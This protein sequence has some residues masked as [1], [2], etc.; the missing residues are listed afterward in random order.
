MSVGR[1]APDFYAVP[2]DRQRVLEI[3]AEVGRV[4]DFE[5]PMRGTNGRL[6][7][8]LT[9]AVAADWDGHRVLLTAFNDITDL[10]ERE[11]QLL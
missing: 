6:F 5:V 8:A 11:H 10:K 7:W 1:P 2:S 3:I 4:R 9:S